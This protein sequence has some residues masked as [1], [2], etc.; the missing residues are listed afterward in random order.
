MVVTAGAG[1]ELQEEATAVARDLTHIPAWAG[2]VILDDRWSRRLGYKLSDAELI[3]C[4]WIV[5]LGRSFA[6]SGL[7]EV[8]RRRDGEVFHIP[9]SGMADFVAEHAASD[10]VQ[11]HC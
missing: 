9:P 6:D 1:Q 11:L 2:E 5:V 7:F 8:R 3:G 4:P 10:R